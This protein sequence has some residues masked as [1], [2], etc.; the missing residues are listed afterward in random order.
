MDYVKEEW[1]RELESIYETKVIEIE[2]KEQLKKRNLA[3][4]V[5]AS[6]LHTEGRQFE[7]DS[8]YHPKQLRG[9]AVDC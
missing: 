4:L 1:V 2:K 8:S 9:R 7:P 6:V 3:Q 5:S